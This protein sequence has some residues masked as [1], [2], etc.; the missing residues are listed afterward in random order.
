MGIAAGGAVLWMRTR[1]ARSAHAAAV[2]ALFWD[3]SNKTKALRVVALAR[4]TLRP[5]WQAGPFPGQ[6][7]SQYTHLVRVGQFLLLVDSQAGVHVLALATGHVEKDFASSASVTSVCAPADR[8][9]RVWLRHGWSGPAE[10][11]TLDGTIVRSVRGDAKDVKGED[12]ACSPR[13]DVPFCALDASARPCL[14]YANVRGKTPF[15]PYLTIEGDDWF[16]TKGTA[17]LAKDA[18]PSERPAPYGVGGDRKTRK[19]AWEGPLSAPGD[20]LHVGGD[21]DVVEG[22]ML[23]LTY[24]LVSGPMRLVARDVKTGELAWAEELPD[25]E[26]ASILSSLSASQ[27]RVYTVVDATLYVHAMTSGKLVGR[28]HTV[29]LEP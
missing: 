24:Q 15:D 13:A 29:A 7:N 9:D 10:L 8:E 14:S 21:R 5:L 22:G 6:W 26:E 11:A 28:L 2:V 20:R 17:R 18:A 4:D 27:D 19:V 23:F 3:A 12:I 1:A 25:T 16:V